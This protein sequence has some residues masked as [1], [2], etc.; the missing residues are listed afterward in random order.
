MEQAHGS[1]RAAARDG[2]RG[3]DRVLARCVLDRRDDPEVDLAG[4]EPVRDPGR[5]VADDLEPPIAFEAVDE[6][7]RVQVRDDAEPQLTT[8]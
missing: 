4:V 7:R 8:P 1:D 3:H 5:D 6:R 2:D